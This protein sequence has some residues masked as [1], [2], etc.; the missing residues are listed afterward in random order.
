MEGIKLT[1]IYCK[2]ICKFHNVSIW[3][4]H[5]NKKNLKG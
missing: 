1:K 2:H 3:L 4:S 5:G